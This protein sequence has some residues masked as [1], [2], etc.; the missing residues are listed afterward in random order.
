MTNPES[1]L[2]SVKKT[3]GFDSTY[4][5]FDLDITLGIN[6]AFGSLQQLGVGADGGFTI[7]DNTTLWSQ[8]ISELLYLGMVK[9]YI[10]LSVK[11]MFDPPGTSFGIEAIEKQIDQLAW[12]INSAF[13]GLHPPSDPF[14]TSDD[15]G[16]SAVTPTYFKIEIVQLTF[17]SVIEPDASDGNTFYLTMTGDCTINTP[18]NGV[19]GHHITLELISNGHAVTWGSGWNFGDSGVPD[20]SGSGRTDVISAVYRQSAASWYAG[21]TPGF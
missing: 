10:F 20:L 5:V 16:A 3:L 11:L 7:A 8:Y 12:R 17:A 14:A 19:D 1:I 13:E 18:V 6:S 2:D 15:S 9:Q 21:F 4:T